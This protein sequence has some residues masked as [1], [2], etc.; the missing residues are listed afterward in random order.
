MKSIYKITIALFTIA[1]FSVSVFAQSPEKMSY[2]AIVRDASNALVVSQT[3]GMQISIL[4]GSAGGTSVYTETQTPTSNVN[5]L[6]AI[7]IGDGAVVSGDFSTIDWSAGPYFVLIETDPTGGMSYTITGTSQLLSVPYALFAKNSG[8][9]FS[10]DYN[11]LN[12]SPTAVSAFTNDAGYLLFEIDSSVTNEIQVLSMSNDTLYLSNGG[13][14]VLPSNFDND[15]TNEIQ[16]LSVSNDTVYLSNGGFVV[17]PMNLDNDSTNEI[18]TL[19][20]SNDTLFLTHGGGALATFWKVNGASI[21]RNNNVGIGTSTPSYP[22]QIVETLSGVN[23]S[24]MVVAVQGGTNAAG[25]YA[26]TYSAI[27]GTDGFNRGLQG[28]SIGTSVGENQGVMGFAD[29][30]SASNVG[31]I[32]QAGGSAFIGTGVY[33]YTAASGTYNYG[34]L[35]NAQST[36]G[37]NYGLIGY[38]AG[39]PTFDCGVYAYTDN[40]AGDYA[41]YFDGESYFDGDVTITGNLSITG[42]IAKGSGTFKIDHPLDPENKYLVHSFVESPDMMNIYN[43]NVVTDSNGFAT[44]EMPEYFEAAN[45]EFR[46]QL[47]V[48]GTFAQAIIKEKMDGNS[49]LIQTDQSGVEVSWQVTGVRA[50]KYAEQNRV[51][52]EEEKSE[53]NKGTYLHPDAYGVSDDQSENAKH[54]VVIPKAHVGTPVPVAAKVK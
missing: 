20:F 14:A 47:T 36:V 31:I 7:E 52:V 16:L 46:Y 54:Q 13:F 18:Q 22:L 49:F 12:N 5:G 53:D 34:V 8:D 32:G 28:S 4:Q 3:I 30:S 17:M 42:S 29:G 38:S 51:V 50:D 37:E 10:G 33:G 11:D 21:Y 44:V 43:G 9:A 1:L 40:T 26:A 19:S 2:Q 41:G 35:G 39:S 25:T 48:I 6:V 45:K 24:A 27:S 23:G 15:S